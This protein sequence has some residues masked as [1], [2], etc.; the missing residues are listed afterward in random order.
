MHLEIGRVNHHCL[1]NGGLDGQP[2]HHPGE[3]P[4]VAPPLPSAVE[5]LRRVILLRRIAPAQAIAIGEDYA[6]QYSPIVDA[7]LAMA[8]G[9]QGLQPRHL[10][11]GQPEKVAHRP[12]SLRRL[13]HAASAR[14]TGPVPIS[15]PPPFKTKAEQASFSD[16]NNLTSATRSSA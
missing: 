14:S 15:S 16:G 2:S 7:G 12:V 13:S 10:H 11:V 9:K 5:G 8:L 6:A 1:R 3:D 4:P